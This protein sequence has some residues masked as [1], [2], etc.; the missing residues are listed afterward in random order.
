MRD[1]P[2]MQRTF[3]MTAALFDLLAERPETG[4]NLFPR[5]V[6]QIITFGLEIPI[7]KC[8]RSQYAKH[9]DASV[10]FTESPNH[11]LIL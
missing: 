10:C 9:T 1:S 11:H 2:Q 3:S 8:C 7:K 4:I 5:N 6:E